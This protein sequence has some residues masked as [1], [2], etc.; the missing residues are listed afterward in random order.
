MDVVKESELIYKLAEAIF[1][2]QIGKE[3]DAPG[4]YNLEHIANYS[5]ESA[6]VFLEVA[7]ERGVINTQRG[8]YD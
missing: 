5:I 3:E 7:K 4:P 6:R 8:L 2:Q 1:I